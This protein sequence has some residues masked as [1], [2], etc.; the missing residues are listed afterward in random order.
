MHRAT[1]R[2]PLKELSLQSAALPNLV[3]DLRERYE[4]STCYDEE[5]A[6]KVKRLRVAQ[7]VPKRRIENED[8]LEDALGA[9][10]TAVTKVLDT[11][12]A[13]ELE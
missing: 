10:R 12:E 4:S 5:K 9:V 3:R 6:L 1:C 11:V 7:V 8:E 2:A 13:V